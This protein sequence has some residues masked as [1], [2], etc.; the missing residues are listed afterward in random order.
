MGVAGGTT[1]LTVIAVYIATVVAHTQLVARRV[2]VAKLCEHLAYDRQRLHRLAQ[3]QPQL[4]FHARLAMGRPPL[5]QA[6]QQP[7]HAQGHVSIAGMLA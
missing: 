6:Q 3:P 1:P 7:I 5:L 4:P 2:T